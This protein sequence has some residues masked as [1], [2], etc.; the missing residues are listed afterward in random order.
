MSGTVIAQVIPILI[1]P[2]IARLYTTEEYGVYSV[3]FS[4]LMIFA[5]LA[6]GRY[7]LAIV[8]PEKDEDAINLA[9]TG[10]FIA[11]CLSGFL[12]IPVL[13]FNHQ[14]AILLKNQDIAGWLFFIPVMVLLIGIFNVLNYYNS[15]L[16]NY[17]FIAVAN[18]YKSVSLSAVQ[19]IL[20]IFKAGVT[21]LVTGQIVSQFSGNFKLFRETIKNKKLIESV[22][23][24]KM[25]YVA[26]RYIDFPKYN[27]WSGLTS[28]LSLNLINLFIIAIYSESVVGCYAFANRVL[29]LP[30]LLIGTSI[31][32]VFLQEA[33]VEK[34]K[35][36]NARK[37]FNSTL[38]KL[39]LIAIPAGVIAYPLIHYLWIPIFSK[40]WLQAGVYA[41]IL[42]PLIVIRFITNPLISILS[43]YE[44]QYI[45]LLWQIGNIIIIA[46]LSW[47]ISVFNLEME[48]FLCWLSYILTAY[49][50]ILLYILFRIAKSNVNKT[51]II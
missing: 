16:K 48:V 5:I 38:L 9:A 25:K 45:S 32:Q 8:L 19:L 18:V 46:G 10:L 30:T 31:G 27:I 40:Q 49:Y 51:E 28:Q 4:L 23:K 36:G 2:V 37:V 13:L 35:S 14:I 29:G 33:S 34:Q 43:V 22:S 6:N 12:L 42:L 44:K 17:K 11:V 3:F 41:Q 50:L 24:A 1:S 21:G 26:K 20:G 15:R 47:S 7:E 39:S